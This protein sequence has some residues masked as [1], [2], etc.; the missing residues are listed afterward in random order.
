MLAVLFFVGSPLE[1]QVQSPRTGFNSYEVVPGAPLV[2]SNPLAARRMVFIWTSDVEDNP[3]VIIT[4][5][6]WG[7][8]YVHRPLLIHHAFPVGERVIICSEAPL[9][10]QVWAFPTEFCAPTTYSYSA[11]ASM[12]N[13]FTLTS[14]V[15]SGGLCLFF[16]N[17]SMQNRIVAQIQSKRFDPSH[18]MVEIWNA[19]FQQ[20]QCPKARC[21][22]LL[23]DRFFVRLVGALQGL[24]YHIEA[25]FER[26]EIRSA[27]RRSAIPV[28]D[29]NLT[30]P[31]ALGTFNEE[32]ICDTPIGMTRERKRNVLIGAGV[33]MFVLLAIIASFRNKSGKEAGVAKT[34]RPFLDQGG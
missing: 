20:H 19:G 23:S 6:L 3:S 5:Q 25:H 29:G 28:W 4:C 22:L 1:A 13:E 21:K 26:H 12:A 24:R 27:C 30:Y 18:S 9:R 16:D 10:L 34:P 7:T 14:N 33:M 31:P 32:L 8:E 17:P 2:I 15:T 11:A